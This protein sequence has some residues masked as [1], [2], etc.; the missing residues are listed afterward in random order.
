MAMLGAVSFIIPIT[1]VVIIIAIVVGVARAD[2]QGGEEDVIKSIYIY[3]VLFATLMMTIG[4]SVAAFMAVADIVTPAPY[5]QS[6]E[7]YKNYGIEK[8]PRIEGEESNRV[9][10]TE[11]EIRERYEAMVQAEKDRQV[12][13]AKNNLIKSFGW[14]V[15]P[16]P[17][18]VYFQ[19]KLVHKTL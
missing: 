1:I 16:F 13:R 19:R 15:I 11:E 10:L 17:I 18:F 5:Y 7:D 9:E 4:G 2:K 8:E 6:Y 14:I 12:A 3:L